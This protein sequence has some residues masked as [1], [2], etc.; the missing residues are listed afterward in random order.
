MYEALECTFDKGICQRNLFTNQ[1]KVIENVFTIEKNQ[2]YQSFLKVDLSRIDANE[3]A[4]YGLPLIQPQIATLCLNFFYYISS[5]AVLRVLLHKD[6]R[7]FK[8]I[9]Q[10][11]PITQ[12]G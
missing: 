6:Q 10:H 7:D 11:S 4:F 12:N 1:K 5:K 8:Q 9:W 3:K 2:K